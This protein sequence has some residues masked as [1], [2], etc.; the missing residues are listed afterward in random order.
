MQVLIDESGTFTGFHKGAISVVGAL[1]IPNGKLEFLTKKFAKIRARLP[2]EKGEVKGRLLNE[3]QVDEVV[4]LLARNEVVF[5]VTALDLGLQSED[6]VKAYKKKHGEDMLARVPN[7]AEAVRAEVQMACQEILNT[8]IPLYLQALTTFE[9]IHRLIG[10]MTMF[11]SQR[12]PQELGAI[13]WV[14]DG[15]DPKA[16]TKWEKWWAH[17]PQ[18]F[19]S[20]MDRNKLGCNAGTHNLVYAKKLP[21]Q[22]INAQFQPTPCI[23][24]FAHCRIMRIRNF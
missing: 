11:Y 17:C 10:H 8:S 19:Q 18:G 9:V 20:R 15:K 12:R 6:E 22:V 23:V 4:T 21:N 5:E 7:F 14:V 3:E 13:S 16:V 1:A 24:H 2:L